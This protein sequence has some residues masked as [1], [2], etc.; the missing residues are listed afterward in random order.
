[1]KSEICL[2]CIRVKGRNSSLNSITLKRSGSW[3]SSA[4]SNLVLLASLFA[5]GCASRN[6]QTSDGTT[7]TGR[8]PSVSLAEPLHL[9]ERLTFYTVPFT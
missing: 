8:E 9:T 1:M 6:S 3:R 7:V 4:A 2:P 5:A